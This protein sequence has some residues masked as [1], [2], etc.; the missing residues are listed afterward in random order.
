MADNK[1]IFEVRAT[2]SG[3]EVVQ[4]QQK[5]LA[6]AVNKTNTKTQ[7]LDKTQEKN[8]GRQKQGLIQTANSTKNFSKLSQ[9]IGS[10]S[11]GLVGA[12]AT[13]AANVFAASAAFNALRQAAAFEQLVEGFTFMANEAGRTTDI[14][15][16]RLKD[17]TGQAL[18]TREALQG[19]S[20]AL[21]AGFETTQL[22]DLAKVARGASLALGR[23]LNDA[24]DRLTRGAIKLEPEIL[25]E[26]GI[27]VRLDDAVEAYAA[28]LGKAA[29]S[30]TQF[31]R[32]QAFLNAINE[33]GLEKYGDIADAIDVNPYDR[34]AAAF[35]DLTKTGLGL[36]N[37]V[38]VP[39]AELFAGSSA[40]LT[41]GLVLFGSTILTQ[42]IPALGNMSKRA[43]ESA[44][45]FKSIAQATREAADES[46]VSARQQVLSIEKPSSTLRKFQAELKQGS[47]DQAAIK[48]QLIVAEQKLARATA[49]AESEYKENESKRTTTARNNAKIRIG[50][51]EQEIAALTALQNAGVGQISAIGSLGTAEIN[52]DVAGRESA[53]LLAIGG[54]GPIAGFKEATKQFKDF[55][56]NADLSNSKLQILGKTFPR[57]GRVAKLAGVGVKFFGTALL[58]AIPFIGQ[59][60]F[61]G[62]ILYDIFTKIYES[63]NPTSQALENLGTIVESL[64]EKFE[65]L[66]KK[67]D[68]GSSLGAKQIATYKV[69]AGILGELSNA[70][71][72]AANEAE[73]LG[74][75]KAESKIGLFYRGVNRTKDNIQELREEFTKDFKLE[76]LEEVGK[77]LEKIFDDT[78][79]GSK[80]LREEIVS[81]L[82]AAGVQINAKTGELGKDVDLT[83]VVEGLDTAKTKVK[84][85]DSSFD[86]LK[87]TVQ[88]GE[89]VFAK[90]FEKFTTKTEY[91][92]LVQ[93]FTSFEEEINNLT[94]AGKEAGIQEIL[95]KLGNGAKKFGIDAGNAATKIPALK[96]QFLVLQTQAVTLKKELALLDSQLEILKKFEGASASATK[97][98]LDLTNQ[99]VDKELE[100]LS[101]RKKALDDL[102]V[103]GKAETEVNNELLGIK[104]EIAKLENKKVPEAQIL[105][106][107]EQ[108][109]L[110]NQ[111][112]LLEMEHELNTLKRSNLN[113]ELKFQAALRGQKVSPIQQFLQELKVAKAVAL[114][115][116]EQLRIELQIAEAKYKLMQEEILHAF[117]MNKIGAATWYETKL[118]YEAEIEYLRKIN[119]E[120]QKGAD[121]EVKN[122]L[123]GA[124]LGSDVMVAV[125]AFNQLDEAQQTNQARLQIGLTAFRQMGQAI[126]ELNAGFGAAIANLVL[127]AEQIIS[128]KDTVADL[129]V[130]L[131]DKELFGFISNQKLAE[132]MAGMQIFST[133]LQAY[134]SALQGFTESRVKEIDRMIEQEKKM[135]GS[136]AQSVAK[137]KSLE[138]KKYQIQKKAFEQDKKIKIA[139]A[140]INT[141]LAATL[142]YAQGGGLF[143]P[144]LA[145][146]ITAL[147][148]AQVALIKKTQFSGGSD[149]VQ[150]GSNTALQIGGRSS[151]IDVARGA[152]S[153]ELAYL[154]GGATT[155]Q[156]LGGAGASLP[157]SAMGRRG[158][159]DGAML[160]GERGPEVIAPSGQVDVIPNY[161]LGG[162]STNVNFT[163]NAVDGQS[164]QNM[165]YTQ[166]G[167]II[168]MIREAANA[169]GEGFLESVDP[170]IYGGNG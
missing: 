142:A 72:Q 63:I 139:T 128:F 23:N 24:F 107:V 136:S 21:S 125:A 99:R 48:K 61:F 11:S 120:K 4:K 145:A 41:G 132:V 22:E 18:S 82:T 6:D 104:A 131:G 153:G 147:G 81:A 40:V 89:R 45:S 10:G 52:A 42:M 73:R 28:K 30:L 7:E 38:F 56:A 87:K 137:I 100:A 161:A 170:A 77:S 19:A 80:L 55:R 118:A 141:A 88:D 103:S 155:G 135:D 130:V 124:L 15:V 26:L 16:E 163:I 78:S 84:D 126:G 133:A 49:K 108:T 13:L 148:M 5:Q 164:V 51:I 157:G 112:K 95:E 12:Y 46:V 143:G 59:I 105:L 96:E 115:K 20:L 36:V 160:V 113:T 71:S 91:D 138:E 58:N 25:D 67:I 37:Y 111:K 64:P 144:I 86:N 114:E 169:N 168:G 116:K 121:N 83:K 29:G 39:I 70:S 106:Q 57:V 129:K 27:M 68:E 158:Y 167:N 60:I 97:E 74:F 101:N 122:I 79:E 117:R 150:S 53:G 75:E 66:N 31:Q 119:E 14:V 9:T 146:A 35:E 166:R 44:E 69:T 54:A 110:N 50:L 149:N 8:Y 159:A 165:L 65:Q 94:A 156:G 2:S 123:S 162:G 34:L 102:V 33:Q 43:A 85:I 134:G 17:I 109:R 1:V 140:I 127:M 3:F 62:G 151:N 154:R 93:T 92:D 152:T 47:L 32:Q 98:L 76:A 90:F